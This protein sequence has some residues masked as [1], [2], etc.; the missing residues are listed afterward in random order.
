[1]IEG[2]DIDRGE[3]MS[4]K[5]LGLG[6]PLHLGGG[7]ALVTW[8]L[9]LCKRII[10]CTVTTKALPVL[11]ASWCFMSERANSMGYHNCNQTDPPISLYAQSNS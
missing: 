7:V 4:S 5:G 6:Q 8:M 3:L 1:M 11:K 10:L 2:E 9:S